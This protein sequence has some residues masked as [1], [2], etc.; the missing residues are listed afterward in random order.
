[1][2]GR[3]GAAA[4]RAAAYGLALAVLAAMGFSIPA[5]ADCRP[6]RLVELPVIPLGNIPTVTLRVDGAPATFLFDTGA[7]R[8]VFTADAAKRLRLN[9]H[10]EYARQMHSLGGALASGDARLASFG[11]GGLAMTNFRVLVGPVSLPPVAGKP[12]DGLLGADFF[13]GF[14][15]DLDLARHRIILYEAPPC[16]ISGPDWHAPYATI[17]ANRSLH[18]RLFFP[19]ILDGRPLAALIDTGAQLTT[20]D[21]ESA[22]GIGVSGT[23]LAHDPVT[24][25]RGAAAETVTSR[26]HRFRQ[27]KIDGEVLR[28]QTIMV[29][30]LGLQDADLVLGADFLHWQRVWLSYRSHL[31]FLERHS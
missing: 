9:A 18:D 20:L 4:I 28:D 2:G 11:A 12:L 30:K 29:T 17:A 24:I 16:P 25:L 23:V 26:A 15:V 21:A 13:T 22:A 14:E 3:P 10:Y 27:L 5:A 8:T 6:V 7:E 19:V 31:I 1:M